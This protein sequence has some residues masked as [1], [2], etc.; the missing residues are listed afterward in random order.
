MMAETRVL[1]TKA[2]LP[3]QFPLQSINLHFRNN[4]FMNHFSC[5]MDQ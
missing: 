1:S 2:E 3:R 4:N 5:S